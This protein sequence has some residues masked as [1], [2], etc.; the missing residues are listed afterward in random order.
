ML[1]R[2]NHRA[3]AHTYVY[4]Q[5]YKYVQTYTAPWIRGSRSERASA[6]ASD[7]LLL[8]FLSF[9]SFLFDCFPLLFPFSESP[10]LILRAKAIHTLEYSHVSSEKR[11]R[12][13]LRIRCTFVGVN[14]LWLVGERMRKNLK[15]CMRGR[16]L[17]AC[18]N[19]LWNLRL[20]LREA[21]KFSTLFR[22]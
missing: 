1:L 20:L 13:R 16:K 9:L 6:R 7:L 22:L 21:L 14:T 3:N 4:T 11:M 15:I 8:L 18:G 19:R 12:M 2:S 5:T 10:V 17:W